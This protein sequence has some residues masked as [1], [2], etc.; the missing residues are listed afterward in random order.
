MIEVWSHGAVDKNMPEQMLVKT[1]AS[2][3]RHPWWQAHSRLVTALLKAN[4]IRP[5][6]PVLDI[7]CGWGVTLIALEK[8]GYLASGHD[9]SLTEQPG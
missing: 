1:L 2:V 7:G 4:D 9:V 6:L 8:T 5:T 3:G